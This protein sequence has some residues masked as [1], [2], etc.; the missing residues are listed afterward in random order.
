MIVIVAFADDVSNFG[1]IRSD[2]DG[3][4]EKTQSITTIE[5]S[6]CLVYDDSTHL[7]ALSSAF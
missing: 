5:S 4:S 6:F 1:I 7:Q 2:D 3:T